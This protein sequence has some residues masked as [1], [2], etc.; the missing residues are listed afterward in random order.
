MLSNLHSFHFTTLL[1]NSS[2][3]PGYVYEDT[4]N[5]KLLNIIER[6][7][8]TVKT[9]LQLPKISK[10]PEKPAAPGTVSKIRP[11]ADYETHHKAATQT[12]R[13]QYTLQKVT[14]IN[15]SNIPGRHCPSDENPTEPKSAWQPGRGVVEKVDK[16]TGEIMYLS[17]Q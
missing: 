5:K 11:T 1:Q 7:P 8:I 17:A 2:A 3:L 16:V 6:T 9:P 10:A 12:P 14:S 4:H 15:K 13:R